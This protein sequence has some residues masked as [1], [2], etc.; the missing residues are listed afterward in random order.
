MYFTSLPNETL[1]LIASYLPCRQDVYALVRRLYHTLHDYFYEYNSGYYHGSA[2]AFVAKHG[3]IGLTE[4]PLRELRTARTRSRT[5][6]GPRWRSDVP[7]DERWEEDSDEVEW[8]SDDEDMKLLT[9]DISAHPLRIAGCGIAE[10]VQIQ[11][12]LLAAIEIN[13]PEIA[14]FYRGNM[15]DDNPTS[16]Q[17]REKPSTTFPA[18]RCGHADLVKYLLERGA[19]PDRYRPSPLYR[20]V[21]DGQYNIIAILLNHRAPLSYASVLRLAVQRCDR[22]ILNALSDSGVEAAICGHRALH[23]AIQR[24]DQEMIEFLRLECANLGQHFEE[25][26]ESQDKWNR[27]GGDGMDGTIVCRHLFFYRAIEEASEGSGEEY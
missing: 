3:I 1:F 2:L 27:E 4:M 25:S 18:V 15:R 26:E 5:P 21:K 19:Y 9:R 12:A 8:D 14:N 6:P 16:T 22:S 24:H 20:A 13:N 7:A 23:I 11:K 10:I 17:S